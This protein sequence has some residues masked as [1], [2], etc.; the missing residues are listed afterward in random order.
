MKDK[1]QYLPFIFKNF[2]AI[3]FIQDT[4][5]YTSTTGKAKANTGK[6]TENTSN[7]KVTDDKYIIA[8]VQNTDNVKIMWSSLTSGY[9][10][11][12]NNFVKGLIQGVTGTFK[13]VVMIS[14]SLLLNVIGAILNSGYVAYSVYEGSNIMEVPQMSY[15]ALLVATNLYNFVYVEDVSK[16]MIVNQE[17][18]FNSVIM[19]II[20]NII[21][22]IRYIETNDFNKTANEIFSKAITSAIGQLSTMTVGTQKTATTQE[23]GTLAGLKLNTEVYDVKQEM[24][25][26]ITNLNIPL[27]SFSY[28]MTKVTTTYVKKT[29]D[30]LRL[31]KQNKDKFLEQYKKEKGK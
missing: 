19:S 7:N 31:Y 3:G 12:I 10:E 24:Q 5:N 6:A 1:N 29:G 20:L 14:D 26:N 21:T 28:A 18:Y 16:E 15:L 13:G 2:K 22:D 4:T 27:K 23:K 17:N 30:D 9:S 8:N 25:E 11:M